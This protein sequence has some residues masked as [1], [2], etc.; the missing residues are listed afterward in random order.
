MQFIPNQYPKPNMLI[1]EGMTVKI[2]GLQ[3]EAGK[4]LNGK[5]AVA[6]EL[7][8]RGDEARWTVELEDKE[9][10]AT[11]HMAIKIQN[12]EAYRTEFQVI[13]VTADHPSGLGGG[14]CPDLIIAGTCAGAFGKLSGPILC[15][16]DHPGSATW[17]EDAIRDQCLIMGVDADCLLQGAKGIGKGFAW[18]CHLLG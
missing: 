14:N 11:K 17:S 8:F 15:I 5:L 13:F 6:K 1:D 7:L 9:G 16:T 2:K 10:G 18:P 4:V 3:S 12:L